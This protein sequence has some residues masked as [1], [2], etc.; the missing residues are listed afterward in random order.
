LSEVANK[1]AEAPTTTVH[2]EGTVFAGWSREGYWQ[3]GRLLSGKYGRPVNLTK[4]LTSKP[5]RA[6]RAPQQ[7]KKVSPPLHQDEGLRAFLKRL[8]ITA[9]ASELVGAEGNDEL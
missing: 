7:Q 3:D 5:Y 8:E 6:P 2:S 4:F 9:K 1:S